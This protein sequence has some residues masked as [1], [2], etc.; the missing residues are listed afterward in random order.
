MKGLKVCL[1]PGPTFNNPKKHPS[2]FLNR[3]CMFSETIGKNLP[4]WKKLKMHLAFFQS[5]AWATKTT[6]LSFLLPSILPSS[7]KMHLP[8]MPAVF[9]TVILPI[10]IVFVLHYASA[11]LYSNMCVP[12]GFVGFIKSFVTTSS[13]VCNGL[14]KVMNFT[15]SSYA[16]A[17][18]GVAT[19][20]I[21]SLTMK[22]PSFGKKR[23]DAAQ[24]S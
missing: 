9:H 1:W 13:P 24:D 10:L 11:N 12:L 4:D 5:W 23:Q 16:V 22:M 2:I 7:F 14:L 19:L 3:V 15:N 18:S 6:S 17:I 20:F 8:S 21:K